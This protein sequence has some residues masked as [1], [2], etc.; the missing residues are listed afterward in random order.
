MEEKRIINPLEA[1][2]EADYLEL[3]RLSIKLGIPV[4]QVHLTVEVRKDGKLISSTRQRSRT[5]NRNFWNYILCQLTSAPGV[6]TD[7][8]AGY[9]SIKRTTG[10]VGA[11]A[12]TLFNFNCAGLINNSTY[13]IQVG[14]G[15]G[16]ESFEGYVLGT[17]CAHGSGA[18]QLVYSAHSVLVQ[19]YD[20]PSKTWTI[21]IKRIFNNNSAADIVIAETALVFNMP[22]QGTQ[23]M[24]NRD[25]L[26]ATQTVAIGA[27]LT[28]SYGVTLT[29]PA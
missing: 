26:G 16:A 28:V 25:L 22:N 20:A 15:T 2:P 1:R 11:I 24:L 3:E 12:G 6:A 13:G 8:G 18:N 23:C 17:L 10:A 21:T 4:P 9:L 27:Q 7:F 5:W 29:F 14:I 19:S